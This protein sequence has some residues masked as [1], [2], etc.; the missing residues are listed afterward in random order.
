MSTINAQATVAVQ[1]H[2]APED[3]FD[4]TNHGKR[5]QVTYLR[6]TLA[7]ADIPQQMWA[8]G[9]L[10]NADGEVGARKVARMLVRVTDVPTDLLE[11][12]GTAHHAATLRLALPTQV[13]R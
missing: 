10:Y 4:V 3:R 9:L 6:Y 7:R 11:R 8:D 13:S 5:V 2:V 1:V 12:I